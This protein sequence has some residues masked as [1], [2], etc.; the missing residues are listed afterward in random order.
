MTAGDLLNTWAARDRRYAHRRVNHIAQPLS[1]DEQW[2]VRYLRRMEAEDLTGEARLG[3]LALV[4]TW[5]PP[6][7]AR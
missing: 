5:Y 7:V 3:A 2:C 6:L 4:S 1:Q